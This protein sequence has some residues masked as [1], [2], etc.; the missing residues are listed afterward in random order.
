MLSGSKRRGDP[1]SSSRLHKYTVG[2]HQIEPTN[3]GRF[4]LRQMLDRLT[5]PGITFCFHPSPKQKKLPGRVEK[6]GWGE[7]HWL[8]CVTATANRLHFTWETLTQ[9][10]QPIA[11]SPASFKK[12]DSI[13]LSSYRIRFDC[14]GNDPVPCCCCLVCPLSKL[15][16]KRRG[17]ACEARHARD[18]HH[19]ISV[20]IQR[21]TIC[22]PLLNRWVLPFLFIFSI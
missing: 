9:S 5:R 22:L 10:K 7:F 15:L 6:G 8:V 21:H 19:L 1:I 4:L 3:F 14:L 13:L 18:S 17:E 16:N 20:A 11:R 12:G 2:V